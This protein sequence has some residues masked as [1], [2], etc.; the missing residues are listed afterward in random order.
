[1]RRP[2][3][4]PGSVQ[5]AIREVGGRPLAPASVTDGVRLR[6]GLF[7]IGTADWP[8]RIGDARLSRPPSAGAPATVRLRAVEVA[9]RLFE[10]VP[11]TVR[12]SADAQKAGGGD[13]DAIGMAVW[14]RWRMR[15]DARGGWLELAPAASPVIAPG[16]AP[17]ASGQ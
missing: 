7:A 2:A 16:Q 12:S 4:W 15:L 8:V 6:S 9:G 13:A 10:Q 11:A 1:V 17:S 3:P 5:L 14:S